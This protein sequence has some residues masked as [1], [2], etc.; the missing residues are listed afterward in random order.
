M[1]QSACCKCNAS[2]GIMIDEED[3]TTWCIACHPTAFHSGMKQVDILTKLEKN[4][5]FKFKKTA[6]RK[7][8]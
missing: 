1:T 6:D 3:G 5:N 4:P 2:F 8:E 7:Y